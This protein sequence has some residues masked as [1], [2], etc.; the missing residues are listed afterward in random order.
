MRVL[1]R[2]AIKENSN[3]N[4]STTFS[5]KFGDDLDTDERIHM[6]MREVQEMGVKLEGIHFH[7]GSGMHGSN[8]FGRGVLQA[9]RCLEIGRMYGH[10]M[11]I[12]DIGGGFPAGN[13]P[14]K[15]AQALEVTRDDPLGYTVMAEPGRHFSS[16]SFYLLTRVLGKRVKAGKPCFHL[17]ESLYHSFNGNLMD[18][19]NFEGS[20]QFYGRIDSSEAAGLGEMTSS[21]LFGMTC[22]GIDVIAKS[23]DVPNDMKVSDWLCFSGMGAYTYG[24]RSTFNGMKSTETIQ[25]W[26]A[27][28]EKEVKDH[29]TTL[30]PVLLTI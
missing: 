3:D 15:T 22:D 25:Y 17:N 14:E 8:A 23:V 18:N 24:P 4:L 30:Q 26:T 27:D 21:T 13:L 5:G 12:M 19:L 20:D 28:V 1:W 6:R 10:K 16:Q 11:T 29:E 2:I 9:R 7:C